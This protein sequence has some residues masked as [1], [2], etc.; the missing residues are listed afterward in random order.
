MQI[1]VVIYRTAFLGLALLAGAMAHAQQEEVNPNFFYFY[2]GD[3]PGGWHWVLGDPGNYWMPLEGNEGVSE[4]QKLTMEKSDSKDFPWAVKLTWKRSDKWG[5]ATITGRTLDLS[6]YEH[7]GQ[8]VLALKLD[9]RTNHKV[10]IKMECGDKCSGEVAI[11]DFLNAAKLNEWFALPI[12]LDCF[13]KQ[14]AKLESI[15]IPF[16]IGTT[17]EMVLHIAE[18]GLGPMAKDE[19]GCMP[20]DAEK[21]E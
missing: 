5:G 1:H 14:G 2:K 19:E 7:N 15:N 17:G 20:N 11:E 8:L 3:T 9:E 6:R 16:Q 13:V 21:K 4:G 18:I 10:H 12:P